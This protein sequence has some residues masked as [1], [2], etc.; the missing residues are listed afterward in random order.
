MQ[1]LVHCYYK[2]TANAGDNVENLCFIAENL[3]YPT[4]LLVGWVQFHG[5][6]IIVGYLMPNPLY[7]YILNIYDLVWLGFMEYQPQ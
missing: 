1:V 2:C 3:L 5:I 4:F 7:I 6:S